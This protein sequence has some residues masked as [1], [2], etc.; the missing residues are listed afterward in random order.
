[1]KGTPEP[2]DPFVLGKTQKTQPTAPAEKWVPHPTNPALEINVAAPGEHKP[3]RTKQPLPSPYSWPAYVAVGG[4]VMSAYAIYACQ[5]ADWL[6]ANPG[7]T[8]EQIERACRLIAERLE[9]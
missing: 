4:E 8:P 3:M 1:M 7:A 6:R 2:A 5:K 9:L